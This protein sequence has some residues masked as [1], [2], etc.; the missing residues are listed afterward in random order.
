MRK[1]A[2]RG[3]H[4][5]II[6]DELDVRQIVNEMISQ[7]EEEGALVMFLGFVKG[8]VNG[9]KV[10]KLKF[11]AYEPLASNKL[12]EIVRQESKEVKDIR[13]YHRVGELK[14][15]DPIIYI[16]VSAKNRH[17]AFETAKRVLERVKHEVPI[18]KLEIREDG[19]YWVVGDNKR[20][21]RSKLGNDDH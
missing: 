18:F 5:S 2:N 14:P 15:N 8:M 20:V 13:V 7:G 12:A 17:T 19:E 21:K 6:K 16:F 1:Q 4:A 11:E 3:V 10:M 9:I